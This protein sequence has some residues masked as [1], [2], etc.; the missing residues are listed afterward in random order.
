MGNRRG[1]DVMNHI[2]LSSKI[3]L[4][5]YHSLF[6]FITTQSS[7]FGC[8]AARKFRHKK[9]LT[10]ATTYWIYSVASRPLLP[11][12]GGCSIINF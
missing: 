11:K 7:A 5:T 9:T 1:S 4:A 10:K 12:A 2:I 3:N 8:R 6:N